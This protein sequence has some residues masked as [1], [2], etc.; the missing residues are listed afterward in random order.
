VILVFVRHGSYHKPPTG[1]DKHDSPLTEGGRDQAVAAGKYMADL[2]ITPGLAV[3][4]ATRRTRKTAHHVLRALGAE[5]AVHIVPHG[6]RAGASRAQIEARVRE[7]IRFVPTEPE[8]VM[9]VGHGAQ[10]RSIMRAF[11]VLPA[12]GQKHGAVVVIEIGDE[13]QQALELQQAQNT[14]PSF[15]A[16]D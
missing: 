10:L 3:S 9:F 13:P 1:E 7:W 15:S 5:Q 6:W 8:I 4:T 2:G 12:Y 11:G 14:A 16:Q